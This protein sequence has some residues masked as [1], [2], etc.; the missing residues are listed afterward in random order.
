[1][2]VPQPRK[3]DQ[4]IINAFLSGVVI[5]GINNWLARYTDYSLGMNIGVIELLSV[6]SSILLAVAVCL[7]PV[8]YLVR[9]WNA[10]RIA[11][12]LEKMERMGL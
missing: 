2:A 7:A 6:L 3:R 1:M 5:F 9:R 12:Q 11:R 10:R 4:L 8:N